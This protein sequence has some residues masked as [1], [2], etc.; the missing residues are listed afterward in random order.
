MKRLS[1]YLSK[2]TKEA[3]LAPL[4]KLLE[5]LMDLLVP[6]VVAY[7]I[8]EG[9]TLNN[10]QAIINSFILL[11]VLAFAGMGFSFTAQY[12]AAKASVGFASDLRQSLFDHIMSLSYK[13]LDQSG[14]DTLITRMTS[15]LRILTSTMSR[16]VTDTI[17]SGT[18]T[19]SHSSLWA[20]ES[21]AS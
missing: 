14:S 10:K 8:N 21:T 16:T 2:Y 3:I 19:P 15:R 13:E 6:L 11:I 12:F 17:A 9:I 18:R 4:F 20:K 7:I 5:A 1:S